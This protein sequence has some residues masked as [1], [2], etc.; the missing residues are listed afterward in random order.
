MAFYEQLITELKTGKYDHLSD[1]EAAAVIDSQTVPAPYRMVFGSFRTLAAIIDQTEYNTLRA[2]LN[3]AAQQQTD[4]GGTLLADMVAMLRLPGDADGHGGGLD[5][6]SAAVVAMLQQ[7][8]A[9]VPGLENVPAKVAAYVASQ[10]PLALR[11][12]AD[13][14]CPGHVQSARKM[15]EEA[16]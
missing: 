14:V 3:A 10:Q 2:T 11:R 13:P 1:A 9:A 4:Q 5:L 16:R 6:G 15:I 8:A 7:F 12:W